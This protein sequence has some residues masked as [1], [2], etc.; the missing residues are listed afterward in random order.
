[1][2]GISVSII[3]EHKRHIHQHQG[4]IWEKSLVDLADMVVIWTDI[5]LVEGPI[6]HIEDHLE[7]IDMILTMTVMDTPQDQE[8]DHDMIPIIHHLQVTQTIEM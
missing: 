1:M 4:I 5:C 3:H 8:E 7:E 2:E 6:H